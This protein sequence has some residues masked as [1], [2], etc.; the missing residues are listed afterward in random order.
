MTPPDELSLQLAA[1]GGA[2]VRLT[3]I[4]EPPPKWQL[5]WSD[6]FD[7]LDEVS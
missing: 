1:A 3:L 4:P 6:D 2:L 5:V 7:T